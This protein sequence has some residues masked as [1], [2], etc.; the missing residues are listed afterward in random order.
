MI[1]ARGDRPAERVIGGAGG[2]VCA[3]K[4][5]QAERTGENGFAGIHALIRK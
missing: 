5:K 4:N 2:K 3:E 1:G